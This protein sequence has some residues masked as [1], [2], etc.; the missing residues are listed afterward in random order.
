MG[1]CELVNRAVADTDRLYLLSTKNFEERRRSCQAWLPS[2]L[3]R[4]PITAPDI[5]EGRRRR[6]RKRRRSWL[7]LS[8]RRRPPARGD[9]V[10][11][12]AM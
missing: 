8:D 9:D 10:A 6:K 3:P 2:V 11:E 7:R 4:Y 5:Q 1:S 12:R